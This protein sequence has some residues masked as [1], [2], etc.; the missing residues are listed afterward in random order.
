MPDPT[1]KTPVIPQAWLRLLLFGCIFCVVALL[2]GVPAIL[3]ITGTHLDAVEK[4]VLQF[5]SGLM[6]ALLRR[7]VFVISARLTPSPS[8]ACLLLGQG[9]RRS[10]AR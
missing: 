1:T 6:A 3:T 5:L 4:D 2:I 7:G 10:Y 9:M 8:A